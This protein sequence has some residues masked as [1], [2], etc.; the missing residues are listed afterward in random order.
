MKKGDKV[1]YAR[2]LESVDI[3]ELC[4]LI[5]R[6]VESTWFVAYE[7]RTKRAYVFDNDKIG[8]TVFYDREDALKR[9]KEK[10][11]NRKPIK[12]EIYYEEY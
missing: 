4:D 5:V 9:V 6:S 11:K 7:K 3:Y 12:R 10:E 1:Y 8:L 2:V